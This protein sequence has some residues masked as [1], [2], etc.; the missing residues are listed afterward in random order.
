MINVALFGNTGL[1]NGVFRALINNNQIKLCCVYTRKLPGYFPYYSEQ[2]LWSL[3]EQ[4]NIP[5]LIG[6][7]VNNDSVKAFLK[8][9]E[10][11]YIIVASFDQ[12]IQRDTRNIPKL[13]IINYHPSLLPRYRGPSPIS[14]ALIEGETITGLT[15]HKL[16]GKID[17][18]KVLYQQSVEITVDD[19]LG[20]LLQKLAEL[21]EHMTVM[22][23]EDCLEMGLPE[24]KTQNEDEMSYYTKSKTFMNIQTD[25]SL[26][27]VKNRYRAF[28]PFPKARIE[29]DGNSYIV[30]DLEI[31][32]KIISFD[33]RWINNKY[34]WVSQ[35]H[36]IQVTV[37]PI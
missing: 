19:N 8:R 26:L 30:D 5:T 1:A 32:N 4:K 17:G 6:E 28:L 36:Q 22:L 12:I 7:N 34:C 35:N 37:A 16:T 3:S 25:E 23:L 9:L 10:I 29:I 21:C 15:I 33:K 31:S 14:W 27:K 2:E 11:D 18:G 20:T 13:G 24:G